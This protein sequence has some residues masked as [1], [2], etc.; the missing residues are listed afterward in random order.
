MDSTIASKY[1][2]SDSISP[3]SRAFIEAD[4]SENVKLYNNTILYTSATNENL[5]MFKKHYYENPHGLIHWNTVLSNY[6][7]GRI[8]RNVRNYKLNWEEIEL[9]D[10]T[11]FYK[12]I[13]PSI[14][15]N[16]LTQLILM[17][18]EVSL[19]TRKR[20][21][22]NIV[23]FIRKVLQPYI[24]QEKKILQD[25]LAKQHI[26]LP[27]L[28]GRDMHR[29][30]HLQA[31]AVMQFSLIRHIFSTA[32][33]IDVSLSKEYFILA[34]ELFDLSNDNVIDSLIPSILVGQTFELL[35]YFQH[36]Y[37]LPVYIYTLL[38]IMIKSE[39][40]RLVLFLYFK[41][42]YKIERKQKKTL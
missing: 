2:S 6:L 1:G 13:K 22:D 39:A 31:S 19:E 3:K 17:F 11:D 29:T 41:Q 16:Y 5:K 30:K 36:F 20:E 27:I 37:Q 33:M 25:I 26:K 23:N 34:H 7:G 40:R 9:W 28:Y 12:F 18:N 8:Q 21:H 15:A 10:K 24:D 35:E 38:L 42:T 14:R 4:V 32:A